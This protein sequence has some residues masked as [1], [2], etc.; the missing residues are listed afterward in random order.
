MNF[1]PV[2]EFPGLDKPG[3]LPPIEESAYSQ[4]TPLNKL[5]RAEYMNFA[6]ETRNLYRESYH[7]ILSSLHVNLIPDN[8]KVVENW[9][10]HSDLDRPQQNFPALKNE[11]LPLGNLGLFER[12][13][14]IN[15]GVTPHFY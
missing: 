2:L 11:I 12:P 13:E 9:F 4:A 7:N 14:P 1:E 8:N 10:E 6:V 5:G 15:F 3:A